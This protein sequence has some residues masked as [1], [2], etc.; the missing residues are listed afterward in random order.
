[1]RWTLLSSKNEIG[2]HVK[3]TVVEAV[4]DLVYFC[5]IDWSTY[6]LV[7]SVL[8]PRRPLEARFHL[9]LICCEMYPPILMEEESVL[10]CHLA[11][12]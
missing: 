11:N 3:M 10:S 6:Y 4:I 7:E 9:H 8:G 5:E 2:M 12:I 1:M